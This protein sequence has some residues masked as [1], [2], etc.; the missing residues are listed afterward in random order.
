MF[1]CAVYISLSAISSSS[2]ISECKL[3]V[4]FVSFHFTSLHF[5]HPWTNLQTSLSNPL[6]RSLTPRFQS[7]QHQSFFPLL[8]HPF[9]TASCSVKPS[10]TH[11]LNPLTTATLFYSYKL[12]T[13]KLTPSEK[14][15]LLAVFLSRDDP[16]ANASPAPTPS[17][18][19]LPH[20]S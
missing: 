20:K 13:E 5:Q 18:L 12:A 19:L 2:Y 17:L 10:F 15:R 6:T 4:C 14:D 3:N 9:P 1:S 16:S 8:L 7:Q 11:T